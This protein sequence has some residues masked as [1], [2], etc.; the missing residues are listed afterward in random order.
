MRKFKNKE[1]GVVYNVA[2]DSVADV[3]AKDKAYVEIK[4]KNGKKKDETAGA[5]VNPPENPE[6]GNEGEN[7]NTE[8]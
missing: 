4:E 1:T 3:F 8:E 2:T 5:P 7:G 6:E